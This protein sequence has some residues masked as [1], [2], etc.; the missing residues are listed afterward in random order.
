MEVILFAIRPVKVRSNDFSALQHI[1]GYLFNSN[2]SI[3]CFKIS[4]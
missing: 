1:T 4:V 3:C 2:S